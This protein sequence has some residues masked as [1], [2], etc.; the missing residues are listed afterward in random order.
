MIT[1]YLMGGLGNQLFQIFTLITY[2]I[3]NRQQ[4]FLPNA[5]QLGT[6][7]NGAT[8][9]H[10]FWNSI[11]KTLKPFLK[12]KLL[13]KRCKLLIQEKGFT[14]EPLEPI[15]PS[16]GLRPE[17]IV[18][19]FGYFQSYKYFDAYAEQICKMLQLDNLR[20]SIMMKLRYEQLTFGQTVSM[21][22]RQGD[23]LNYP[24]LYYILDQDYYTNALQTIVQTKPSIRT[25]MCFYEDN[26]ETEVKKIIDVCKNKYPNMT[27]V[28]IDKDFTVNLED[29]EQLLL[30]S[31][32]DSNIIANS[33]FSWWAAYLNQELGK[34]V[35]YPEKWFKPEAGK[36]IKDMCPEQWIR[37]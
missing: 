35:V 15:E 28:S 9:R 7:A 27:F 8:V 23:Y 11:F 14:Y 6:D 1:C 10:T 25:V 5:E 12:D 13:V 30:M 29:W 31:M 33:T 24:H 19:L 2:A 3:Q 18:T 36:D 26:D 22:F 37:A 16:S 20:F 34:T 17:D 21:H 4:F 32:C